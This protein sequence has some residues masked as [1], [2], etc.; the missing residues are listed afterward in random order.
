MHRAVRIPDR[1]TMI[2]FLLNAILALLTLRFLFWSARFITAIGRRAPGPSGRRAPGPNGREPGG[3]SPKGRSGQRQG[4]PPRGPRIDR[5]GAID[6]PFTEIAPEPAMKA[7]ESAKS[8]ARSRGPDA[9]NG[10]G[11]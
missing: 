6:V 10:K 1:E 11:D 5:S 3:E 9:G 8:E 4:E 2:R 7:E